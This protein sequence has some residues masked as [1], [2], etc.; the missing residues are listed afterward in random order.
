[1]QPA[2]AYRAV[3]TDTAGPLKATALVG[4]YSILLGFDYDAQPNERTD[5][6]GFAVHRSDFTE[7]EGWWLKGQIRFKGD[8]ADFGEDVPTNRAPLQK[9]HWGDYAA[10][11]GNH[12]RYR[13]HAVHGQPGS[14]TLSPPAEVQV[15]ADRNDGQDLEIY[16]NRGVTAARAYMRRFGETRPRDVPAGAAYS[17]LSRGLHEALL[18]FVAAA[19]PGDE[20]KVA[21][22]EL[23]L[24][25]VIEALKAAQ[26]R[27]VQVT[28]LYHARP[29]DDQTH[30]NELGV[31]RLRELP[32]TFIART[33]VPNISHNKF[34]VHRRGGNGRAVWTGSTNFTENGFFMQTNVGLILRGSAVADVYDAYFEL[35][36][37]DLARTPMQTAVAQLSAGLGPVAGG[38]GYFA[39]VSRLDFL[40]AACAVISTA[41]QAVFISCPFGLDH[42]I[43]TALNANSAGVLEYGLVN[44]TSGKHLLEVIDRSPNVWYATPAWLPEYDGRIW[45]APLYGGHKIHV[46]SIVVDPWSAKPKVVVGSANFSDESVRRNDENSLLIEGD[47][48]L[49][50]SC[51]TEFLRMFDHYKFRDYVK[52]SQAL[53]TERHLAEDGS[54][55]DDYYTPGRTKFTDRLVF[56]GP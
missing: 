39:P 37:Q 51:A 31:D 56:A 25:S 23:E 47:R 27:G 36:R 32:G 35:L 38:T 46:K 48:R 16:F 54:W 11:P 34:I 7:N 8:I 52:R 13:V 6:L 10:K 15:V 19:K 26:A 55:A 14:L 42:R 4:S 12:Y 20:L 5:F 21:I 43:V 17:W 30:E 1:M 33:R 53:T 24:N 22:Y 41:Q 9:F 50:A 29:G 44:A 28:L 40:D 3:V 18:E 49:A 45:D 2:P